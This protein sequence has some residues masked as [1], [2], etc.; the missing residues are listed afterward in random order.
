MNLTFIE[1]DANPSASHAP[2]SYCVDVFLGQQY[3]GN[4]THFAPTDAHVNLYIQPTGVKT[5]GFVRF[6]ASNPDA[7]R[8]LF[9]E[10]LE[11]MRNILCQPLDVVT[12]DL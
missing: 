5:D 2:A 1:S 9:G 7:A 4:I 3:V 6:L 8:M 11:Q 12:M 10:K